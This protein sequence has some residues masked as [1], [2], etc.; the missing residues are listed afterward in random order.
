[1]G[2]RNNTII[3]QRMKITNK[4]TNRKDM[5]DPDTPANKKILEELG[6]EAKK[7]YGKALKQNSQDF[8][9]GS[10]RGDGT[11]ELMELHT[12]GREKEKI[13]KELVD[14]FIDASES[15]RKR[16]VTKKAKGGMIGGKKRY[17]NGGMVMS[18]RGVRD[19]KMS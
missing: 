18:N 17:M 16:G 7:M 6:P 2:E 9:K 11:A 1:M 19:T 5:F 3:D 10:G 14:S 13:K 4:Q 15:V 12:G 8:K